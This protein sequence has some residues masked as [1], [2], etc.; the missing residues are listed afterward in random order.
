MWGSKNLRP[1]A[2]TDWKN[3]TK[4][5]HMVL[6][7]IKL[8]WFHNSYC[9]SENNSINLISYQSYYRLITSWKL[10]LKPICH[11]GT[12]QRISNYKVYFVCK[13]LKSLA[14]RLM[15]WNFTQL[16]PNNLTSLDGGNSNFLHT[17]LLWLNLFV[18]YHLEDQ[19]QE[20]II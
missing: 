17:V 13:L 5:R 10:N 20:K 16:I 2:Q 18:N 3:N 9:F 1:R 11:V 14:W 12:Q 19:K 6:W 4:L 7:I 15:I 8:I